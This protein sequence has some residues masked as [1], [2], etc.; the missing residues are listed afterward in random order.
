MVSRNLDLKVEGVRNGVATVFCMF[1]CCELIKEKSKGWEKHSVWFPKVTK[2][3]Y[4]L[5]VAVVVMLLVALNPALSKPLDI[6][7]SQFRRYSVQ[8]CVGAPGRL[9]MRW[10]Y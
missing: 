1:L 8:I 10:V 3:G 4:K 7:T 6:L 2:N 5:V 9:K